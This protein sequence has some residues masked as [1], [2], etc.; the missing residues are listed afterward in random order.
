MAAIGS[1]LE[2]KERYGEY[3]VHVYSDTDKISQEELEIV[4]RK[5]LSVSDVKSVSDIAKGA[6]TFH[7]IL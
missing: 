6:N 4:F 1:L 3:L 5:T 2:L 7:V